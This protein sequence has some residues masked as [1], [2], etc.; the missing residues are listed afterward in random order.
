[1]WTLSQNWCEE[2]AEFRITCTASGLI[3]H[4]PRKSPKDQ[5]P[6]SQ[7]LF[8]RCL[9]QIEQP[10][11]QKIAKYFRRR[12]ESTRREFKVRRLP[13]HFLARF[14]GRGR[15]RTNRSPIKTNMV[16]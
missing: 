7:I 2:Q 4:R 3:S 15:K 1:M 13:K 14:W 12:V 16:T 9:G 8:L 5:S 11:H 6:H 10:S